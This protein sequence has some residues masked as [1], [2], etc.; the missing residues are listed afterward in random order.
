MGLE[1]DL[2]FVN[3]PKDD[4]PAFKIIQ[5]FLGER[6]VMVFGDLR[7][8]HPEILRGYLEGRGI[9]YDSVDSLMGRGQVP[10]LNG[11][12]EEY[13]VVGMGTVN[14]Y[15]SRKK[16]GMPEGG[17]SHYVCNA[18]HEHSTIFENRMLKDGWTG[19]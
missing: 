11:K 17:S 9:I 18:N 14:A 5:M 10:S 16:F 1:D 4:T 6:P 2:E 19:Y 8:Q 13:K 7:E 12:N 15:L 3:F